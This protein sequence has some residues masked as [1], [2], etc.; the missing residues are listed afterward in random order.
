MKPVLILLVLSLGG[1]GTLTN[2]AGKVDCPGINQ[3]SVSKNAQGDIDIDACFGKE[4]EHAN[5]KFI[6]VDEYEMV[7][8]SDG[9][10]A[11]QM[12]G[13][14]ITANAEA[15]LAAVRI[16]GDALKRAAP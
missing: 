3:V 10:K 14:A 2:V 16:V 1:C 7:Y 15:G 11:E 12:Q 13:A 6:K 8:D 4:S 9:Q 5:L